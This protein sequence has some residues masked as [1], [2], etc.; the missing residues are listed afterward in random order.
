MRVSQSELCFFDY[1]PSVIGGQTGEP[2]D[3]GPQPNGFR[4]QLIRIYFR[5]KPVLL[6]LMCNVPLTLDP[7]AELLMREAAFPASKKNSL[8][9]KKRNCFFSRHKRL[10]RR[11]D[12]CPS[13]TFPVGINCPWSK[14]LAVVRLVKGEFSRN[15]LMYCTSTKASRV[16]FPAGSPRIFAYGNRDGRCHW[17]AGFI[18]DLPFTPPLHSGAAPYSPRPT[19]IGSQD[20]AAVVEADKVD[21]PNSSSTAPRVSEV[22]SIAS[23]LVYAYYYSGSIPDALKSWGVDIDKL[24]TR[25]DQHLQDC[26]MVL[27][28]PRR[29]R[30][31]GDTVGCMK[32]YRRQ[33]FSRG[34]S[35]IVANG[36]S[37]PPTWR[38]TFLT[39]ARSGDLDDLG[40]HSDAR[41]AREARPGIILLGKWGCQGATGR[42]AHMIVSPRRQDSFNQH[43]R[44]AGI[45]RNDTPGSE[46]SRWGAGHDAGRDVCG[47]EFSGR[48]CPGGT[49]IRRLTPLDTS[50][51]AVVLPVLRK[52]SHVLG[53]AQDV[54]IKPVHDKAC[55]PNCRDMSLVSVQGRPWIAYSLS[56]DETILLPAGG[57]QGSMRRNHNAARQGNGVTPGAMINQVAKEEME[58]TAIFAFLGATKIVSAGAL[59]K[60]SSNLGSNGQVECPR[61]G[62]SGEGDIFR[63]VSASVANRTILFVQVKSSILALRKVGNAGRARARSRHIAERAACQLTNPPQCDV[64][65]SSPLSL[66]LEA[67]WS[68]AG[69]PSRQVDGSLKACLKYMFAHETIKRASN[70]TIYERNT[71]TGRGRRELHK[72]WNRY[73]TRVGTRIEEFDLWQATGAFR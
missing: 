70:V 41:D 1:W 66:S 58:Q 43:Q 24:E 72:L 26:S 13:E 67:E 30:R 52:R 15:I 40:K 33:M 20:L 54:M 6:S 3:N 56:Q 35:C 16:R 5:E 64:T 4:T 32:A 65:P 29:M 50:M 25:L 73:A 23:I 37:F 36:R 27:D 28:H 17:L 18:G 63:G 68:L 42:G 55:M 69:V 47:I 53:D 46:T 19:L 71:I 14:V 8:S 12:S 60:W 34:R 44:G 11:L 61:G 45:V 39:C 57:P 38:Q 7:E 59:K 21:C 31:G 10:P 48:L 49:V 51:Q 9:Y 2:R 22:Y 62:V